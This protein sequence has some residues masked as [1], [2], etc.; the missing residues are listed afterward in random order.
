M[1]P[2]AQCHVFCWFIAVCIKL[3]KIISCVG[4]PPNKHHTCTRSGIHI[5]A[6]VNVKST[7]KASTTFLWLVKKKQF[8]KVSSILTLWF[9]TSHKLQPHSRGWKSS[10]SSLEKEISIPQCHLITAPS[11]LGERCKKSERGTDVGGILPKWH[12]DLIAG[13]EH[14]WLE[15]TD[16]N[17][18]V[19][20]CADFVGHE[21]CVSHKLALHNEV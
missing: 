3:L 8:L 11:Q 5:P 13:Q 20:A 10:S 21:Q 9:P 18:C 16:G 17:V 12:R 6:G 4:K 15:F 19:C 14:F 7:L 2:L 1:V